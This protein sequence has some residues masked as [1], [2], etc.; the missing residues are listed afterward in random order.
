METR[1]EEIQENIPVKKKMVNQGRMRD[2]KRKDNHNERK[3]IEEE[4]NEKK[5]KS[6]LSIRIRNSAGVE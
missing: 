5:N 1:K 2:E 4:K 3:W 6:N